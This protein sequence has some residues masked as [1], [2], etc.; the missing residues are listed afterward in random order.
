MTRGSHRRESHIQPE[1]PA[2]PPAPPAGQAPDGPAS[3]Q[4]APA[5]ALSPGWSVVVFLWVTAFAVLAL[6]ELLS[7]LFRR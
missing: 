5:K 4:G 3:S 2:A 1:R 6:F 7:S